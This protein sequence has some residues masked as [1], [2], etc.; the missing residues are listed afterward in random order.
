MSDKWENPS[1]LFKIADEIG[2][3]RLFGF[4][5]TRYIKTLGLKGNEDMLD[6]GSGSGAGSKYLA[7]A[8][9]N[10]GRLTCADTSQYWTAK[11]RERMRKYNNVSFYA[12]SLLNLNF[13][14]GRFDAIYIHYALHEVSESLREEIVKEFYRIL[15]PEGRLYIKEPQR[16][17][18]G[19]PA[20]EIK[21]LMLSSKLIEKHGIEKNGTY[22]GVYT[23]SK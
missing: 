9:Q 17:Y 15:K 16:A 1:T 8:L 6:F 4:I 20:S 23:K 14:A 12:D 13:S 3:N 22:S 21:R 5:Y 18:D 19:M 10:G 7:N 11:A 2:H